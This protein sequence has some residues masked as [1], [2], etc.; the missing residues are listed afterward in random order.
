MLEPCCK[1]CKTG[2]IHLSNFRAW[3]AGNI[4]MLGFARR[5]EVLAVKCITCKY[6]SIT[7]YKAFLAKRKNEFFQTLDHFEANK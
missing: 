1:N 7:G 4:S 2:D 5:E 6:N 3:K